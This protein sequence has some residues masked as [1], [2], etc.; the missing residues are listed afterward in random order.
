MQKHTPWKQNKNN[1]KK[2]QKQN[3]LG[4]QKG[5]V[6]KLFQTK[7]QTLRKEKTKNHDRIDPHKESFP[8]RG[9]WTKSEEI[10]GIF[11][12]EDKRKTRK[13]NRKGEEKK[14]FKAGLFGGNKID[15]KTSKNAGK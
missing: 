5:D 3:Q 9:W 10:N 7:K 8:K 13:E 11:E 2:C 14:H 6:R 1:R 15:K 4:F 12:R